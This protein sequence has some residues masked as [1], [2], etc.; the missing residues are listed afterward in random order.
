V[1]CA[2]GT[3][4]PTQAVAAHNHGFRCGIV[5]A[6]TVE[7]AARAAWLKRTVRD[8]IATCVAAAVRLTRTCSVM[9]S[10]G[11]MR[12]AWRGPLVVGDASTS[13]T[14]VGSRLSACRSSDTV[15]ESLAGKMSSASPTWWV[16]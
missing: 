4:F 9:G 14:L 5:R 12:I 6:S 8:G 10:G 1:T 11:H 3:L 7:Q 13:T 15:V 16:G 2:V